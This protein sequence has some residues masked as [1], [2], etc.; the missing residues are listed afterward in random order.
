MIYWMTGLSGSGKTTIA[1]GVH[2]L[3]V[4]EVLEGDSL[5]NGLCKGLGYS[6]NDRT[7]NLRRIAHLA[8]HLNRHTD[9][10]VACITPYESVRKIIR[11]C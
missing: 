10:I 1:E 6:A 2:E 7:E 9:V 3:Q 5:R 11:S 4:V 8:V